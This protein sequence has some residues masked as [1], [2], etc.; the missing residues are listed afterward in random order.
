MAQAEAAHLFNPNR[1]ALGGHAVH[2]LGLPVLGNGGPDIGNFWGQLP[3]QL[4]GEL[5]AGAI[6]FGIIIGAIA[7]RYA[8]PFLLNQ[9]RRLRDVEHDYPDPYNPRDPHRRR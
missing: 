9:R 6:G 3:S 5:K 2:Q 7:L 8:I 4:Q 1:L